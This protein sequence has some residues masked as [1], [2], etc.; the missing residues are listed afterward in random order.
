MKKLFAVFTFVLL[1]PTSSFAAVLYG[2]AFPGPML[3]CQ[4][5]N[6]TGYAQRV[7][8]LQFQYTV[9]S[10]Q[11]PMRTHT[12]FTSCIGMCDLPNGQSATYQGPFIPGTGQ[13]ISATC[14][15]YTYQM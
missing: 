14:M 4:V 8:Q 15:A 9:N 2:T 3:S 5:Y 12:D 13:V 6:S 10:P 11:D 1:I 7:Y